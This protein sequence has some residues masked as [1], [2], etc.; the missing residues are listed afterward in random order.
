MNERNLLNERNLVNSFVDKSLQDYMNNLPTS[1][2]NVPSQPTTNSWEPGYIKEG[3]GTL[4][5][6]L[7]QKKYL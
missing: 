4:Y 1:N 6:F 7:T 5:S 3:Q 2:A